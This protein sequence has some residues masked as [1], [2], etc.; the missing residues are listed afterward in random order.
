[1]Q[2]KFLWPPLQ[3]LTCV[4]AIFNLA[5]VLAK[6]TAAQEPP[7][8]VIGAGY[9]GLASALELRLLGY[10]VVLYEKSNHVGGRAYKWSEKGFTF[11]A[12]PSWYWMPHVF[13]NIFA[14]HGR[15]STEFY[16]LTRL[17][18]AYGVYFGEGDQVLV[19]G[20]MDG[21][22]KYILSVEPQA[23]HCLEKFITD[24][25]TFYDKG[26][27]E[28]IWKPMVSVFEFLD[29]SLISSALTMNMFGSL[30]T[31]INS[32]VKNP[33]LRDLL[34][35]PVIFLGLSPKDSPAMYSLMTYAGHADGTWYPDGG[36]SAPA[37][38]LAQTAR[39]A[40]VEIVLDADVQQLQIEDKAV[41]AVCTTGYG[42]QAVSGV[43]ASGDYHHMEQVLLPKELRLNDEKFWD[44]QVMSPSVLL[45]YV[46]V[47]RR[48]PLEH[49][50]FFFDDKLGESLSSV[51]DEHRM[52][53]DPVFYVTSTTQVDPS[54]A[55]EGGNA[56][57]VLVP[58]S[59]KMNGTDNPV[60][61][62]QV[63]DSIVRR[64]EKDIGPFQKDIVYFRDY[65]PTDFEK[66]FNA[67]RGNAFG[68]ANLLSQSLMFKPS[69][70]SMV[71]NLVF[72]GH[73]TN[74][75]PGIPPA[76]ASGTAA[77]HLLETK[78]S[79]PFF[80]I[81][82]ALIWACFVLILWRWSLTTEL[83]R[84]KRECM[85]LIYN[86]GRTF[87]A[88]AS[89]MAPQ[90]FLDTAAIYALM[91]IADDCVDDVDDF[92]ERKRRIDKFEGIF[93]RCWHAKS[94][95][96]AD[97]PV[98]PAVIETCN[99]IKFPKSFF[100]RFFKAMRSDTQENICHT[101]D[102]CE[103]YIDGSAAVV[104]EFMLPILMPHSS[105]QEIDRAKP[106][107]MDLGRAFQLTNFCRDI[108][109]DLDIQR[110][111]VPTQLCQ[112]HGVD[113]R[114]RTAQQDGFKDMIEEVFQKC[115]AYYESADK[116]IALLPARIRPVVLV[117]AKLYQQIQGEVR[118]RNY[119]IFKERVRVP[120]KTKLKMGY[121]HVGFK[122]TM[123]IVA[124]EVGLLTLFALDS[125]ST[126]FI[127]LVAAWQVCEKVSWPGISYAGFH[128]L[129]TLPAL[130]AVTIL[131]QKASP[132][133]EYFAIAKKCI[134][135]LCVVATIWTTPWDNY[136][137]ATGVWDYP[138]TGH[139]LAV[140]GYVPIE[141]Y[142]FFTIQTIMVGM[143]WVWRGNI[144]IIPHFRRVR[145][146]RSLGLVF[147]AMLFALSFW[148][149]SQDQTQY[150]GL[151][152]SW[153]TPILALQWAFGA[154]ALM[155]QRD[156]WLP[157]LAYSAT[158]LCIIDRWA[159]RNGAWNIN[160]KYS[161][162][163]IDWLPFE[164]A[165]FFLVTSTM[166]IWGL[167]LAM[168]VLTLD[169]GFAVA[170][171]R[172]MTWARK[173]EPKPKFNWTPAK[174]HLLSL[175]GVASVCIGFFH[176]QTERGQIILMLLVSL[177][178]GIPFAAIS[179][180]VAD[181]TSTYAR[182]GS[183]AIVFG[184]AWFL[185]PG[186]AFTLMAAAA[187][188]HFGRAE[189]KSRTGSVP[190]IDLVARGGM[191][192][193]AARCQPESASWIVDQLVGGSFVP[194][195]SSCLHLLSS[196]QLLCLCASI[197]IHAMRCHQA[198]HL[199]FLL[200]QLLLTLIFAYM[201]PLL[202]F[203]IYLNAAYAPRLMLQA[204]RLSA[205]HS[206]LS[207][208]QKRKITS[209]DWSVILLLAGVVGFALLSSSHST[210]SRGDHRDHSS[211][212]KF[213]VVLLSALWAPSMVLIRT[214][215]KR[216]KPSDPVKKDHSYVNSYSALSKS[217]SRVPTPEYQVHQKAHV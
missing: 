109:E 100:E 110:Q 85:R 67:F 122:L 55:P 89:L 179:I 16:N 61:R 125:I 152:V 93:W 28:W 177:M 107:A 201:P 13:E 84:S 216:A 72:A 151:I 97:H 191:L 156:A 88:G 15:H 39:D 139:V 166:C 214:S 81:E 205:V 164:E 52:M 171:Q 36:M 186:I 184:F 135:L 178:V 33:R 9:S 92:A 71:K 38:A 102:D 195:P 40:G 6:Q 1:M 51:I 149:L 112:K 106:H 14:K 21:L 3:L 49:H 202:S 161:L 76:L 65:G 27:N 123:R 153:S 128:C 8:A 147:F 11:D 115:D 163:R 75:G 45:Y 22:K 168:N 190:V 37:E 150:L 181:R 208:L 24:A 64:M 118:K 204:S 136:L 155:A 157:P 174:T 158:Y 180:L 182:S 47:K 192:L 23:A 187:M 213:V 46:G 41:K 145:P 19:P 42:C 210:S 31:E 206:S 143:I 159:I 196:F 66:E 98:M 44:N 207:S 80:T 199:E 18:P 12:G 124:F 77:A 142:A 62:K 203:T 172:V 90:Q 99:R 209:A 5:G 10:E 48:L 131:A 194:V 148:M 197:W 87:F 29:M 70:D 63:F 60:V 32:C 162:P 58:I 117:A 54:T 2:H 50:T 169:C 17:D 30:E 188:W 189:T 176:A 154:D 140:V 129:C 185:C 133:P 7:V 146:A 108:D 26:I 94:A 105:Q 130:C 173:V 165:Y 134:G 132:T 137:V 34:N 57:F 74:P 86:H 211:L 160:V 200:E 69:L 217:P 82:R 113:L 175:A 138:D 167:Q 104:G 56:L 83:Q 79:P 116:G 53:Q 144:D 114:R 193:F 212:L 121:Q 183:A 4:T 127:M 170:N 43:V 78:L 59:Y 20:D 141:E 91:R 73:L 96:E 111:Y 101:W 120:T 68:H 126:P 103:D 119:N 95:T 25:K 198:H 35:W 215:L